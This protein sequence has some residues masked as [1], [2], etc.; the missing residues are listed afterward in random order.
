MLLPDRVQLFYFI[1]FLILSFFYPLLLS[2]RKNNKKKS[3]PGLSTFLFLSYIY[4]SPVASSLARLCRV[5]CN[6]PV[7]TFFSLS[8]LVRSTAALYTKRKKEKTCVCVCVIAAL[9]DA[10]ASSDFHL[11]FTEA[12][13]DAA[14]SHQAQIENPYTEESRRDFFFFSLIFFYIMEI[15]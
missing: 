13:E 5:E 8:L 14:V 9:C 4:F 7:C 10:S 6:T 12:S 2:P 15:P 11:F 3:L 1:F